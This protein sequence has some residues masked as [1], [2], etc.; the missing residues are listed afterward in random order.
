[1]VCE[2]IIWLSWAL[3]KY[4]ALALVATAVYFTYKLFYV[5]LAFRRKY[6][7]YKNVYVKPK[8]IP[9]L[10]ELKPCLDDINNGRAF[11]DHLKKQQ[12]KMGGK[13]IKVYVQGFEPRII[14]ASNKAV[15]E[16][17]ALIPSKIDRA[18]IQDNY[19]LMIG[20]LKFSS[21]SFN[22]YAS[23][24][25]IAERRKSYF[26]LLGVN[27]SSQHIPV[28]LKNAVQNLEK[29]KQE[30]EVLITE[31]ISYMTNK[32][33]MTILFG[34]DL[35]DFLVEKHDYETS[36][37]TTA[38]YNL[39]NFFGHLLTAYHVEGAHP[40]TMFFPILNKLNVVNPWKRNFKNLSRFRSIMKEMLHRSKDKN[41]VWHQISQLEKFSKDDIFNDLLLIIMG[42]GDTIS[43]SFVSM[44]YFLK[45]YPSTLS[46]LKHE[47]AQHGFVKGC[48]LDQM[49]TMENI[50]KLEYLSYV[51]KEVLR[52]DAPIWTTMN[53]YAFKDVEICDVPIPKGTLM[54]ID[55]IG[56]HYDESQWL[57]P[58]V[59]EPD[60]HDPNSDFAKKSKDLGIVPNVYSKRAFGHGLRGCPGQ[61]FA[62]LEL[63]VLAAF[64]IPHFDYS[65]PEE[66]LNKEG[67]GFALGTDFNFKLKID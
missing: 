29:M 7:Q 1:M 3:L 60:R 39:I 2:S 30:E 13:D 28:I 10:G 46:K 26:K 58:Y 53:Y 51:I 45:K 62:N 61:A 67:I 19:R 32:I 31:K 49:F 44:L 52:I 64:F 18:D 14:I 34:A 27:T 48:D 11:Y 36:D 25:G 66:W 33:F 65:V 21:G 22:N 9:V 5:P 54:L 4:S 50:Q 6:S 41:S 59:F 15:K 47:L 57:D 20:G 55:V 17:A 43:R 63:K 35:E 8:F 37:G 12:A 24:K 40:M 23:S 56:T 38:K 16:A 42:G